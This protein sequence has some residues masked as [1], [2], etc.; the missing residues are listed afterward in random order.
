MQEHGTLTQRTGRI[1]CP[2]CGANNFEAVT[3][4]WKCSSPLAAGAQTMAN[5]PVSQ[6][7]YGHHTP[8][9]VPLQS[10]GMAQMPSGDPNV[11]NRA[12]ILLAITIPWIGLPAGW[13]FMMVEDQKKQRV[14]RL[15]VNW[16]LIALVFHLVFTVMLVNSA[17]S[18][19]RSIL[20]AVTAMAKGANS[21]AGSGLPDQ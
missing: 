12:A 19:I 1:T 21:G 2:K 13:L 11:A 9:R 14:G 18:F 6:I 5:T 17:A 3:T 15:C 4:C 8:E 10:P 16:S 7:S 20:P